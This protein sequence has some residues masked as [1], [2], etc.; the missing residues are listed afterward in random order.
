MPITRGGREWTDLKLAIAIALV[1]AGYKLS[2]EFVAG[3]QA[4]AAEYTD[5][6]VA[7]LMTQGLFVWLLGLLWMAYR[8]WR[9][10]LSRKETLESVISSINPD[11]LMVV[12]PDR[13]ITMCNVG[14]KAMFGYEVDE[15]VGRTTDLLYA[16]RRVAGRPT[17]I[18]DCIQTIGFHVGYAQGRRRDGEEFPIEIVTG[19][20][21]GGPGAVVL[22]R[23][24][25][26]RKRAEAQILQAK[27]EAESANRAKS[28]ALEQLARNYACLK[29]LEDLRDNLTRMIVH[30]LKSPLST[31]HGY[32]GVLRGAAVPRLDA[33]EAG[34]LTEAARLA[35][36]MQEM[37]ASLLDIG[38]LENR[39]MP[40][41]PVVSD[42]G[43]LARE[44]DKVARPES[45]ALKVDVEVIG[46]PV[47]A[48]CDPDIIRR[49]LVNLLDNAIKFSPEDGT[50]RV[51]V[52]REGER[53]RVSVDDEGSGIPTEYHARIF[54]RFGQVDARKYST[55]LGLT[56][57]KLAVE[58]HGGSI[59]VESPSRRRASAEGAGKGTTLWFVLPAKMAP[60]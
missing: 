60:R 38:R 14:V 36:R 23:D 33:A 22:M 54:E 47:T 26:E 40:L 1:L 59:G 15:V 24:V 37:I 29:E 17:G 46:G 56:F 57:C 9:V 35:G 49:V 58:A 10:A 19:G 3:L 8:R 48:E 43:V 39:E 32:L 21:R 13:T 42:L 5:L 52:E 11:V 16:D 31:I 7:D 4:V 28:A 18:R 27:E 20:L 34:Y 2:V 30:D 12:S 55:G 6:P 50:V 53:A 45:S 41:Q 51:R 44:A 25:T